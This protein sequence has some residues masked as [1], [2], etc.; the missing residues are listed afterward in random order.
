AGRK[1]GFDAG[2]C[3]EVLRKA[4]DGMT[5]A[6]AKTFALELPSASGLSLEQVVSLFIEEGLPRLKADRLLV[7][8]DARALAKAFAQSAGGVKGLQLDKE[9]LP[10]ARSRGGSVLQAS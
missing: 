6:G 10:A 9:P 2:R 4:C 8:G 1:G 7:M 5:L 3:R